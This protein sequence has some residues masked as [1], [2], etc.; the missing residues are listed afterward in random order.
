MKK[1]R[2]FDAC[3]IYIILWVLGS[4]Q[5]MYMRSSFVSL[6]FYVP[7]TLMTIYYMVKALSSYPP[8][9]VMRVF[10]VFFLVM[11]VYG[12]FL[13][14]LND[15]LGQ[16]GKSFLMMLL[17]SLGPIFPFY[18]FSRKGVLTEKRLIVWFIVFIVVA[19]MN[20][21]AYKSITIQNV[22]KGISEITNNTAYYF[23]GLIPFVFLLYKRP[24]L[25]YFVLAYILYFVVTS[26]KRGAILVSAMLLLWFVYVSVSK[27]K[28][29]KKIIVI[30]S[31]GVF[32]LVGIR[33]VENFY[34]SSD[35]FQYRVE[36][37]M[38]GSSSNRDWLYATLWNHFLNNDNMFQVLFGEGAFHSEN[39][40]HG[41]KAHNDWLELLID[42][43]VLGVL[44]Y[45]VYWVS[46]FHAWRRSRKDDFLYPILGACLIFT[47]VRTFFSMSFSDMP[48]YTCMI[49]G[50][51][52]GRIEYEESAIDRFVNVMG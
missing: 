13:V 4:V 17:S 26:L 49:M 52:F 43:G 38:E 19:T 42:C 36:R 12:I 40:S 2:I 46:F 30:A 6:L 48:F 20:F 22:S 50:C 45:V 5:G 11:C 27:A 15:A 37:T 3:N 35:Y 21:F 32:L 14:I 34:E 7:S 39:V 24:I 47:F 9:G 29:I 33:F 23:A 25:Q 44:L 16:D 28:R 10:S 18:V 41:L 51:C 31:V 8:K 1:N